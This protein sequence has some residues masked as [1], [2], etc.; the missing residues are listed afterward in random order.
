M[1]LAMLDAE[2][3]RCRNSVPRLESAL[4]VDDEADAPE[5]PRPW[6]ALA[7]C[8]NAQGRGE[9][10]AIAAQG[11]ADRTSS[12]EEARYATW[13]AV[14]ATGWEDEE[15]LESLES[16]DDIWAAMAREQRDAVAFEEELEQRRRTEFMQ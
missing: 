9:D 14:T 13:L 5:E 10:A 4:F 15:M 6:L 3:G 7:R 16:G 12:P 8:L 1:L 2:A 11:A